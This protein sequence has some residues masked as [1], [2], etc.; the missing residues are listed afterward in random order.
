VGAVMAD[1][2]PYLGVEQSFA[3]DDPAGKTII[4]ENL[5]GLTEG[6]ACTIIKNQGLT[7]LTIGTG[8]TVTFQIPAA[9]QSIPG[10]SQVI[11]Y[12]GQEPEER[13]VTVPDFTGMNRQ[14]ASDAALS[15]G[16]Y[17]L[18]TGNTEISPHVT[19]TVQ[20]EPKDTVV[21]TGTTIKLTF[22]D[23]KAAD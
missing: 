9:G 11:L 20:S 8:E 21:P 7:A 5:S 3:E 16:L 1:I 13:T 4:L 2:L 18:V 6:E 14:Q 22:T 10:N 19:V 17:I 12:L 15:L 23:T